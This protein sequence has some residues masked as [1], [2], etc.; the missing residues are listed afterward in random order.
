MDSTCNNY[1]TGRHAIK[2]YSC[3]PKEL[4]AVHEDVSIQSK[5]NNYIHKT[6]VTD[7]SGFIPDRFI[8]IL[9]T[10]ELILD[11]GIG[12]FFHGPLC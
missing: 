8:K 4:L 2:Y 11:K 1:G 9:P 3:A 6:L 10:Y 5:D 12:V 7:P